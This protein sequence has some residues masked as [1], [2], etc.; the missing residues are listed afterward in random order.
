MVGYSLSEREKTLLTHASKLP[1]YLRE[2]SESSKYLNIAFCQYCGGFT[3]WLG[4]AMIY[5]RTGEA[6]PP[7]KDMPPQIRELY[8][9]ARGV[10][11]AS[12]RASAALLRVVLE[13]LLKEAGY[14]RGRLANRLKKARKDG[15]LSADTYN[16]AERLR[17]AGNAA[18]HYEP[19]KINPSEGEENREVIYSLFVFVNEVTEE[20]IA[21]PKRLGEMARK[22]DEKFRKNGP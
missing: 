16:L 2:V 3:L 1:S 14:R 13:G 18:A 12:P 9:E 15:K 22:I 17:Y 21:K 10:L 20:L 19:W 6:P 5:P 8:E 7:H 4:N 11:P